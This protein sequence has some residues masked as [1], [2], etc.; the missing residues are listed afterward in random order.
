MAQNRGG[1]LPMLELL[2]ESRLSLTQFLDVAGRAAI[3][4]VLKLSAQEVAGGKHP[5]K[6]GGPV[7]WHGQQAGVVSLGQRKLRIRKPRLRRKGA[8]RG[9]EV[10]IPAY[11]ALQDNPQLSQAM[12]GI[13]LKGVSTR[14]YGGVLQE[15]T[16]TVG[17]SKSQVSREFL[18]ASAAALRELAERRFDDRD[19]LVIYLDGLVFGQHHVLGAVG[20]DAQ[21]YKHVLGIV[22]GASEN[23]AAVTVLLESLVARGIAPGRRRL[24]VI[25]GSKAL[26]A[27]I[28]AVYGKNPVQRCRLHKIRNV[29][30]QLPQHLRDQTKAV[31]T[32]AYRLEPAA[33]MAQLE[34]QALW[35][36]KLHPTVAASL[37]EGL[38]ETFTINHMGLPGE[39]RRCLGS[40]NII[41]SP[42]GGVRRQTRRVCRWRDGQMVLRWAGCTFLAAEPRF[43]R[44]H[45]F[46]FL[47]IL[48]SYL[49][50]LELATQASA[51]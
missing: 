27:G 37:R 50:D 40:T 21:G 25:D 45:G 34:Q 1:L 29:V 10:E 9:Q 19:M 42:H 6:A 8:G 26:R 49:D 28:E 43:K 46:H 48:K 39:L 41:E 30:D 24:F 12:M 14:D 3:E 44:L 31:M 35:L 47:W 32:A 22:E 11:A 15:M 5:G 33:G 36:E 2:M 13:L 23:A 51:G 38:A 16:G 20:V 18:E 4:A 17:V 7:R